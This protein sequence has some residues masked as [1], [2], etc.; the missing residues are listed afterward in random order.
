MR[1][2][3]TYKTRRNLRIIANDFNKCSRAQR[4]MIKRI[5]SVI[6]RYRGAMT[7]SE[8]ARTLGRKDKRLTPHD[9]KLL[10]QLVQRGFL[11]STRVRFRNSAGHPCGSRFVYTM[12]EEIHWALF[13]MES[14]KDYH[15]RLREL[16]PPSAKQRR[17]RLPP[18]R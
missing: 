16:P 9:R 17:F 10:Q 6:N 11:Q 5:C 2:K 18:P 15:R 12:P 14:I 13:E 7:R 1:P 8:I 4:R 3:P